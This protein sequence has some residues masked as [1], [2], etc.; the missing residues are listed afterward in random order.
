METLDCKMNDDNS[1]K[2]IQ[3]PV[4]KI[5]PPGNF[6]I[7]DIEKALGEGKMKKEGSQKGCIWEGER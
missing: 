5:K 2:S 1:G 3:K 4:F 7:T 6:G